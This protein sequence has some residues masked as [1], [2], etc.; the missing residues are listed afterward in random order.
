MTNN[1]N[2]DTAVPKHV[3]IIMDG[4]RRWAAAKHL[5]L[6]EGYRHGIQTFRNAIPTVIARNIPVATFWGF[7]TENWRRSPAE[8]RTL[9]RLFRLA[10]TDSLGWLNRY[11]AK[12]RISGRL[13]DFPDDLRRAAEKVIAATAPNSGLT[14]NLALS[15]GGRD[16]IQHVA[17]RIASETAGQADAIAAVNEETISRHLYTAG[18]PDV[19]LLIRTGGEKRLSGFLPWQSAYAELYFTDALWPDFDEQELDRALEDYAGRKRNFG[20]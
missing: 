4:N 14:V 19:D 20:T 12:L 11:N 7:S 2:T 5:P 10:V 9:F 1:E 17:R 3:A 8:L 16:E 18:L 13:N 15:Y 6:S